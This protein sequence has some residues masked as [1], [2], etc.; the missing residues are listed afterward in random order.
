MKARID[1]LDN[2]ALKSALLSP[3]SFMPGAPE[4]DGETVIFEEVRLGSQSPPQLQ[5]CPKL[6]DSA[7]EE[8]FVCKRRFAG[9][10]P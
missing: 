1:N 9:G 10:I 2:T 7:F 8:W 3:V 5:P 6:F 4:I